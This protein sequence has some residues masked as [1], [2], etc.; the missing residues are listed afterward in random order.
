M[1]TRT[2]ATIAETGREALAE[3][4]RLLGLLRS[5]DVTGTQPAAAA[6]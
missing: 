3:M 6:R 5:G 2:L 4:R 1:A